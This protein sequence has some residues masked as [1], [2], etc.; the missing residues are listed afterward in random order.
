MDPEM[1]IKNG[2]EDDVSDKNG[3]ESIHLDY[4]RSGGVYHLDSCNQLGRFQKAAETC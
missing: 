3:M 2:L 4:S 1:A